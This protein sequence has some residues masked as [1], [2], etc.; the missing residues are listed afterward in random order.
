MRRGHLPILLAPDAVML[1][2]E[3]VQFCLPFG[4]RHSN[5]QQNINVLSM[6]NMRLPLSAIQTTRNVVIVCLFLLSATMTVNYHHAFSFTS[7]WL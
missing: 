6:S 5:F 2:Y 1:W 7:S 3:H 4:I